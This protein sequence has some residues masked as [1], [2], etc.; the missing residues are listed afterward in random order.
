MAGAQVPR[1][2]LPEV[3]LDVSGGTVSSAQPGLGLHY[4]AG[5][6]F[7]LAL[8]GAGGIAWKGGETGHV[9]RV[10]VQ[11]RFHLDPF[12]EARFGLYGI[13]GVAVSHEPF[14][15]SQARLVVG[16]GVELPTRDESTIAV[17]AALAGGLR[18][19]AVW[20]RL[21]PTRR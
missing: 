15:D 7:R 13:G 14:T 19:S 1:A 4:A 17:E 18:V 12:R 20:R 3:R 21:S 6:Y 11:G 16:A 5:T 10:E 9:A 8:I 2:R